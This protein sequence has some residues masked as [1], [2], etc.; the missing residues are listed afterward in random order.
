MTSGDYLHGFLL[1]TRLALHENGRPSLTLTIP[2]VAPQSVGG[3]IALY[4]RAVGFYATFIGV[5]AY[6]QPGVEA[7]KKAAASV[8]ELQRGLIAEL[9]KRGDQG[10]TCTGLVEALG[11]P[12]EVETAFKVLERLAANPLSGVERESGAPPFEARYRFRE[13]P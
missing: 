13:Q 1:G 3:L 4:E 9:R 7:G 2:D 5:N 10:V 11:A 8:L 6:H 12:D